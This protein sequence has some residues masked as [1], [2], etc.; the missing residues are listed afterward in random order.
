[1]SKESRKQVNYTV[2][3]IHEFAN[4]NRMSQQAAYKYLHKYQGIAFLTDYYD[5]EHT[6]SMDD[7]MDDMKA[8]CQ[9]NGGQLS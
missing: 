3:C 7:A 9:K 6:L 5:I 8:I 4:R 2:A 1:M